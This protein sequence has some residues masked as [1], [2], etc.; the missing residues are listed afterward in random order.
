[1][2]PK[3]KMARKMMTTQEVKRHESPFTSHAWNERKYDRELRAKK[4]QMAAHQRA[5]LRK[6]KNKNV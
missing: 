3:L 6:E 4:Q 2:N 1:M 5:L